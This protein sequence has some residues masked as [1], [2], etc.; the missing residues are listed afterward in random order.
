MSIFG[1]LESWGRWLTTDPVGFLIYFIY[2][3]A[4]ILITLILHEVAH[5]YVAYRC[6]D[7]TAKMLGRLSLNPRKHLD[8]IGTACLVLFGFGWARPVPVNPR[9]F[10]NGRKDDF[11]VS[12]AGVAVNFTLF[13]LALALA[14]GINGLLWTPLAIETFTARALISSRVR[15]LGYDILLSGMGPYNTHLMLYP[16]LQHVQRFLMMLFNMNLSIAVF[17]LLPIPPLDGWH[18]LDDLVLKGRLSMNPRIFEITR[19]LLLVLMLTGAL[20]SIL[21]AVTGVVENRVLNLFLRIS[22]Q[23]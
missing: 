12:I 22:G 20:G 2:F 18:V 1:R 10:N 16:W 15:E 8:P 19:I 3:A 6:G 5:G 23:L 4:S 21:S 9:N 7:P 14:V 13:L 11:L 17:N